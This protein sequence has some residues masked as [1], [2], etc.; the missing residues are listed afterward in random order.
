MI[1]FSLRPNPL[2]DE[3]KEPLEAR[4]FNSDWAKISEEIPP[5]EAEPEPEPEPEPGARAGGQSQSQS[6]SQYTTRMFR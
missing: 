5:P 3:A 4:T 1:T 6:Q 2:I